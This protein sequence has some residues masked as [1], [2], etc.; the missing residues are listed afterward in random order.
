VFYAPGGTPE[1]VVERL[2]AALNQ[3]ARAPAIR[4]RFAGMGL[5]ALEGSPVDAARY[6]R[7]IMGVNAEMLTI[8]MGNADR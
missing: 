1:A 2:N 6:V 5:E 4:R 7:W 3:V 8:A